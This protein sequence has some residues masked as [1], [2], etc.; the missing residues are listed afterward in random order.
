MREN[1]ARIKWKQIDPKIVDKYCREYYQEWNN[2]P[3]VRDIFY[4]FI[5]KL[6]GNT[7]SAYKGLSAWLRDRRLD[8]S[9][10]WTLVR[11]GGGRKKSIGDWTFSE[12]EDFVEEHLEEFKDSA[13]SYHLPRWTNQPN[14]VIVIIEKEA[15]FPPLYNICSPLGVDVMYL[16]GYSGWRGLFELNNE[17]KE[18]FEDHEIHTLAIGDFD[19]SG[20]D[21]I[22]SF[23]ENMNFKLGCKME[24]E[25]VCV[26]K[27][28]I[29]EH[30][31]PH[32]PEDSAELEKLM[33]DPRFVKWEHGAYR[34]ETAAFRVLAPQSFRSCIEEAIA[35]YFDEEIFKETEKEEKSKKAEVK[36][37]IDGLVQKLESEE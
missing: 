9:I 11:D 17:I 32:R 23:D 22:R 16:R 31:L 6:W 1:M 10:H 33:N 30:D 21:I 15:D 25:K 35:K 13:E 19:P 5:D 24:V 28:Q 36:K 20:E 14:K 2:V 7:K 4:A 37:A 8:G 34:V 26:T 18:E 3:S 29:E 27:E 12:V